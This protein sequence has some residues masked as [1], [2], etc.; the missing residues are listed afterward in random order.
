MTKHYLDFVNSIAFDFCGTLADLQP[1]STRIL[2]SWLEKTYE[3]RWPRERLSSVLAQAGAEMP[4][5]SL[6]IRDEPARRNH[7]SRFN[8]RVLE[9]LGYAGA[10]GESLY[11]HF[12]SHERHW[13][14]KPE[15]TELLRS[16][17]SRGYRVI[18]ASNFDAMLM[19]ALSREGV[20][21]LFDA[22]FISSEIGIE[23][24]DVA[25][26]GHI[27]RSLNC[28]AHTIAMVG[29]DAKLDILPAQRAGFR[30]ILLSEGASGIEG[31]K[32]V[33]DP[34]YLE[35]ARLDDILLYARDLSEAAMSKT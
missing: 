19:S 17:R 18:L 2:G 35:I 13:R 10:D 6:L 1:A 34:G 21:E 9:L 11:E 20:V 4:Y 25:F 28:A 33:P 3:A 12:K 24:P 32:H 22:L 27:A 26:Y 16:L 15:T 29:D 14:L 30:P 31:G 5:S 8:S 7:F 23:K